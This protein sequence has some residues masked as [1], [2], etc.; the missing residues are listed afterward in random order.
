MH[1]QLRPVSLFSQLTL[2]EI[3][4]ICPLRLPEY[5]S[6]SA[7]VLSPAAA[8]VEMKTMHAAWTSGYR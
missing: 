7:G 2:R 4:G 6:A 1:S 5:H 3:F 8:P